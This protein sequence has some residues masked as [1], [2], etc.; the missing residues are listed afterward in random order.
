MNIKAT[1][2]TALSLIAAQSV[3]GQTLEK[4]N[5]FNE[6]AQWN[7]NEGKLSM[8]VTPQSDYW[9]ISHYGFTV[10]DAPFY[11]AEYVVD[12]CA[13][14]K[15]SSSGNIGQTS[16]EEFGRSLSFG[17]ESVNYHQM[18]VSWEVAVLPQASVTVIVTSCFLPFVKRDGSI[19]KDAVAVLPSS[20]N[21]ANFPSMVPR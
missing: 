13:Y 4:M 18:N 11:Y 12:K 14:R 10:D 8:Q 19:T 15:S 9:R 2:A 20:S 16:G 5:W 1:L 3:C 6:P 7:I 21:S 17:Q